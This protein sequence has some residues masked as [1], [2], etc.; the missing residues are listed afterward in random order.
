MTV[1]M[2]GRSLS[3]TKTEIV[4]EPSGTI[5]TTSA[6]ADNGG[7][8]SAFSPTDLCAASLGACAATIMGMSA[9]KMGVALEVGFEVRKDMHGSPRRLGTLT[10]TFTLRTDADD[11][12]FEAI[13]AA[14]KSCPVRLSLSGDVAVV[15]RYVR[16]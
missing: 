12:A 9:A 5:L 16:A 14:G 8:G 1:T 15:E 7:D 4:H 11:A 10:L 2:R 6:P 3:P 13:V